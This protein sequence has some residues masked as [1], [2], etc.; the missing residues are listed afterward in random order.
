MIA[1]YSFYQDEYFG[2]ML[3]EEEFTKF[4][5]RGDSYLEQLTMGRYDDEGL[6]EATLKAVKMAECAIAEQ[7]ALEAKQSLAITESL[8]VGTLASESVGAHSVSYRSGAEIKKASEEAI[9]S[10]A[11]RYL[12]MTGLLYRGIQCIRRM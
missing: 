3:T 12:G 2:D 4:A 7:C 10:I 11:Y 8:G 5:T 1:D 6:P 9:R